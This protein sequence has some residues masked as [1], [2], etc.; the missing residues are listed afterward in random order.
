[1][2]KFEQLKWCVGC[3]YFCVAGEKGTHRFDVPYRNNDGLYVLSNISHGGF[4]GGAMV[5]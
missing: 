5:F 4:V 1:M 2:I 3:V